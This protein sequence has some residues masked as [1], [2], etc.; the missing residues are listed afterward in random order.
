MLTDLAVEIDVEYSFDLG[1]EWYL[2]LSLGIAYIS[3]VLLFDIL[4]L[5]WLASSRD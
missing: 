1:F 4:L 3:R 5:P 2:A